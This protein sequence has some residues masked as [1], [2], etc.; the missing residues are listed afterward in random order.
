MVT[1]VVTGTFYI[2]PQWRRAI[3]LLFIYLFQRQNY[4]VEKQVTAQ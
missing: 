1:T 4:L 2:L 3:Y